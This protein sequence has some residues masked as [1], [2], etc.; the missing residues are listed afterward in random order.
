M[1]NLEKQNEINDTKKDL[2]VS[3]ELQVDFED[4]VA[5][6]LDYKE[7]QAPETN[8][9]S[10][11]QDEGLTDDE[12]VE[13]VKK[14]K[15]VHSLE[16]LEPQ[17]F[18]CWPFQKNFW[19][20]NSTSKDSGDHRKLIQRTEKNIHVTGECPGPINSF[21]ESRLPETLIRV[22]EETGYDKPTP[23]QA[24]AI[25]AI[26][27]GCN[28]IGI[29]QTGSGKTAAYS[30]P[31]IRHVWAQPRPKRRQGPIA[32]VTAPT[33]ELAQQI[34]SEIRKLGAIKFRLRVLLT[35]G[36]DP[37]Y[38]QIKSLREGVDILVG[39]PGRI[40]DLI[41]SKGC[42]LQQ[43]TFL[44][45]DEA[46]RMLDLGFEPQVRSILGQIRPDRQVCLFSATFRNRVQQLVRE[47]I[48]EAVRITVGEAGSANEDIEQVV[49]FV[50]SEDEK[51][52]WLCEHLPQFLERGNVIVFVGT[53]ASCASLTNQLRSHNIPTCAIHGETSQED[54]DG[55]LKLFRTGD[56]R[57]LVSTDLASRGLDIEQINT[58]INYETPKNI[59]WYVH[60]I[61]RTGR[62]G[63]KG[64]AY[65]LLT[66]KDKAFARELAKYFRSR[67]Q[68]VPAELEKLIHG[69]RSGSP[70]QVFQKAKN[71][72]E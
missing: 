35:V 38:E 26:L 13:A 14:R 39:T 30:L 69:F 48:A 70:L 29:A 11:T 54:R 64:T 40:I 46:D 33:R 55:F 52:S 9:P 12:E 4:P 57:L 3:E 58:V 19:S 20:D 68:S 71:T 6:Y 72:D 60:R 5:S 23:I 24:Q 59:E 63:R 61:G 56:I 65:T 37:K 15:T 31:M 16:P 32:L 45:L 17:N 25:P 36:G 51:I 27:Y 41:K 8:T 50:S 53:R 10:E 21:C 7:K 1:E 67:N 66:G 49:K 28:V 18:S 44:V 34:A 42:S 22:I 47:T 43:V 2:L 62:A